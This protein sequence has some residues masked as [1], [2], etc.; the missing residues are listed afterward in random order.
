[1]EELIL[2]KLV[3]DIPKKERVSH[4]SKSD[5]IISEPLILNFISVINI[6]I[7]T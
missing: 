4:I 6:V 1:M 7:S 2:P 5:S 3:L